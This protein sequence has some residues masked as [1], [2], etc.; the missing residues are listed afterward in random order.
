MSPKEL[1]AEIALADV[2][3]TA[4]HQPVAFEDLMIMLQTGFIVGAAFE[5]IE[6]DLGQ[7][8]LG[9]DT[10]VFDVDRF[11]GHGGRP[12]NSSA[13]GGTSIRGGACGAGAGGWGG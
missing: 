8:P 12:Q 4:R 6:D 3:E 9:E 11:R 5:I 10:V 2:D 7:A 13:R 1:D